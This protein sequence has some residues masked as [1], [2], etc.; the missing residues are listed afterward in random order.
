MI[1]NGQIE[2]PPEGRVKLEDIILRYFNDVLL[3]KGCISPRAHRKMA[4][5]ILA[6]TT[7]RMR[8]L[9]RENVGKRKAIE[10]CTMNT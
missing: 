10:D 8:A 9:N 1:N 6:R 3:E 2:L 7:K 4:E 5:Q